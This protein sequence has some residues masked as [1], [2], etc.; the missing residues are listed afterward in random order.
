MIN[1]KEI[2]NNMGAITYGEFKR[3]KRT[4]RKFTT[5]NRDNAVWVHQVVK[6][7]TKNINRDC[8]KQQENNN[9]IKQPI[10]YFIEWVKNNCE[11]K[12]FRI[13]YRLFAPDIFSVKHVWWIINDY[14]HPRSSNIC[15]I[16]ADLCNF[17]AN[18]N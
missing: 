18:K 16:V 8:K 9:G 2:T 11:I 5:H 15:D 17:I 10:T 13:H 14:L 3:I 6:I 4:T 12:I 1:Y 7:N